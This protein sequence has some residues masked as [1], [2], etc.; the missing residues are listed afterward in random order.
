VVS[1][2]AGVPPDVD[3][4][5]SAAGDE[6][7]GEPLEHPAHHHVVEV[8]AGSGEPRHAWLRMVLLLGITAAGAVLVGPWMFAFILAFIISVVLHEFGHYLTAKRA[9]M[10]VTEFF[11]GFG[12]RLWS[13][14][15]GETDYGIKPIPAGAY[16]RIIG[17]S[18]LEDVD[19][20]DE[21]RT[22]RAKSYPRRLAVVLAGPAMN[23]L[24]GFVLFAA[25]FMTYGV[26]S[27][28]SW[29]IDTV[30]VGS[31]A[32]E[33]G[34]RPGDRLVSIDGE[35]V[36]SFDDM[37]GTLE[38]RAST[39]ATIVVERDGQ[40]LTL[41][42]ELGWRLNASAAEAIPS[43]PALREGDLVLSAGGQQ[44]ADYDQLRALLAEEGDDVTLIIERGSHLYELS[45]P[46]P[47]ELPADGD[48]G[49]L[50]V[51]READYER[52]GPI[53]A[54]GESAAMFGR[55]VGAFFT[56]FGKLF[57]PSGI[58][59]YADL[60]V[61]SSTGGD[62]TADDATNVLRPVA[63]SDAPELLTSA[64]EA[65]P[66]SV[67]GIAQLG[68]A[69]GERGGVRIFLQVLAFVN[70]FLALVNLVPLLPF[71][72]GHAAVAT[73]EAIRGRLRGAP[74]RVD[75]A[76]LLPLTYGVVLVLVVLGVT[77]MLLDISDPLT[78]Q[79]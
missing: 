71:D 77:S 70:F 76:R 65:R 28:D 35:P 75:M 24:I 78:A 9:G 73:Y 74:Y 18:N 50:G 26:A 67:I 42:A 48:T 49:F 13:F 31:A 63:G 54:A 20:V 8:G 44:L 69:A 47:L 36:G 1:V 30:G 58:S 52:L 62:E 32:D 22:Y 12:P 41:D 45:L 59:N 46:R 68:G 38:G 14:R 53:D 5:G 6:A 34:I 61:E 33:A 55:T 10:K 4:V 66:V 72:G 56:G 51:S 60:V 40:E 21:P 29:Q 17:M 2:D 23:I 79:P 64:E 16:V 11:V 27:D 3:P 39:P 7:S 25:L 43:D 57:S 37:V 15:R 19:P